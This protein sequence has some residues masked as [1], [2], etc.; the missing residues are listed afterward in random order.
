VQ[1]KSRQHGKELMGRS[2]IHTSASFW[3]ASSATED[4]AVF[5]WVVKGK[6]GSVLQLTAQHDRAGTVMTT[7]TL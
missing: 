1:G 4:R 7:V 6:A 2:H 5:H 3:P